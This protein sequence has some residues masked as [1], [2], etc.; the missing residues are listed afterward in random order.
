MVLKLLETV[1][2][3]SGR[4]TALLAARESGLQ[5]AGSSSRHPQRG[6]VLM[7]KNASFQWD[8]GTFIN[9][10][11]TRGEPVSTKMVIASICNMY[12]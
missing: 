9:L 12:S 11:H 6:S 8:S 3:H 10:Q 1:G 7:V 4:E 5:A 2:M